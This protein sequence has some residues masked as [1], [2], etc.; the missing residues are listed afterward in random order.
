MQKSPLTEI[1]QVPGVGASAVH[2]GC[3]VEEEEKEEEEE[4]I[5]SMSAGETEVRVGG[6]LAATAEASGNLTLRLKNRKVSASSGP[7][8]I[9]EGFSITHHQARSGCREVGVYKG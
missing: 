5:S 6:A 9:A 7:M 8:S 2:S 3:T 4:D 1:E